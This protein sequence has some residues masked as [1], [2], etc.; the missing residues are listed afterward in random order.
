MRHV[1][2]PDRATVIRGAAV[3]CALFA[4]ITA[5]DAQQPFKRPEDA[6]SALADAVRSGNR[7]R[8]LSV[9]G[10]RGGDIVSSGDRVEDSAN[11]QRFLTAY[12]A[13][14]RVDRD[15]RRATLIVGTDDFPLPIPIIQR[16]GRWRF[17]TNAG[18]QEILYRRIG[19]NELDTIQASL[20]YV[21]A[22]REYAE[23][24]R[25]GLGPGVF[26]RRIVSSPGTRDGLF[27]PASQAGGESPLG[28]FAARAA[29]EG[30]RPGA[31]PMPYHGY[32]YK[33][34]TRQGPNAAGGSMD[35]IVGGQMRRGFALLAY[36]ADYGNSGVMSFMVNQLG[37]VFQKDLGPRTP[38]IAQEIKSFNPDK[39]WKVADTASN[40]AD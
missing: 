2:W 11:R 40:P 7:T 29:T 19:R 3:F 5:A 13:R 33:V 16:N 28:E 39:T 10:Q 20:A 38:R 4:G 25:A 14:H 15:G 9:L 26:A 35:Y 36:P 22:Q 32:F 37:I 17:D 6:A 1:H 30:Y 31:A 23:K 12:D 18:R 24:D 27:W 8:M 21:D 34:L